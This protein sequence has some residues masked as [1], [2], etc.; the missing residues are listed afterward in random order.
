MD[1][2]KY[3]C[4]KSAGI[5]C[6]PPQLKR[7]AT[8]YDDIGRVVVPVARA[9]CLFLSSRVRSDLSVLLS[10]TRRDYFDGGSRQNLYHVFFF[11]QC[12]SLVTNSMKVISLVGDA[13][14]TLRIPDEE[15]IS[16]DTTE[17]TITLGRHSTEKLSGLIIQGGDGGFVLPADKKALV[18][19]IQGASFVDTQVDKS[20]VR[21]TC[22]F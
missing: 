8:I 18:S 17:L 21:I 15:M 3:Y 19:R 6:Q 7:N 14:L 20:K 2:P 13:V 16:I 1:L 12:K 10:F 11:S 4:W 5:C 22:Y 9:T